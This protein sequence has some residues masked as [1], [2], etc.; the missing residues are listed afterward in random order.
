MYNTKR[1][2][3]KNGHFLF[4]HFGNIVNE[5]L[6]SPL[7]EVL[8]DAPKKFTRPAS[9][10]LESEN[11]YTIEMAIPGFSKE[12]LHIDVEKNLLTISVDKKEAED[13]KYKL[14]EFN[15]NQFKRSFRLPKS[16]DVEAIEA[17]FKKGILEISLPKKPVTPAKKID[18][19]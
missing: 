2:K 1:P 3:H 11:G 9:N 19:K 10:V 12:D 8:K 5:I 6:H 14:R 16:V 13:I 18:I 15:Y 4:P 17:K 7:E